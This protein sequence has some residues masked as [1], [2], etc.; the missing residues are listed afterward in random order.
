MDDAK[1]PCSQEAQPECKAAD[2][3]I[4]EWSDCPVH[5]EPRPDKPVHGTQRDWRVIAEALMAAQETGEGLAAIRARFGLDDPRAAKAALPDL[6]TRLA[7]LRAASNRAVTDGDDRQAAY[8]RGQVDLLTEQWTE[9]PSLLESTS[10][11]LHHG[12]ESAREEIGRKRAEI[13]GLRQ[14]MIVTRTATISEV[15][16]WL[17]CIGHNESAAKVREMASLEKSTRSEGEP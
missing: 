16:S 8:L 9:T 3:W 2:P 11:A 12:L 10:D 15:A 1:K 13:E 14:D 6:E 17:E 5:G 4:C 7:A